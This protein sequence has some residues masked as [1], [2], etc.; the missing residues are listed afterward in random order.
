MKNMKG[1]TAVSV[2]GYIP[3]RG[4]PG[5][6]F[7]MVTQ[8][9]FGEYIDILEDKEKW[10]LI[11][12]HNDRYEGWIDKKCVEFTDEVVGCSNIVVRNG[13]RLKNVT[14]GHPVILPIGA[15]LPEP[16]NGKFLLAGNVFHSEETGGTCK[17]GELA[18]VD[19]FNKLVSIPYLWGGRC[20]F[21]FDC[22]GLTQFLCRLMGKEI[23][24][25]ASEQSAIGAPL[26]FINEAETGDLAFFDNP[27]GVIHHVGMFVEN[28]R[29]IHAS[30]T[31]RIDPIDQQGIYNE[32]L[33][34]YTYKLRV[35][36]RID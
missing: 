19:L 17:P 6:R 33:K 25:D 22:S 4:E 14:T 26:S 18:T 5:E 31:V 16:E 20:G 11:R 27:D 8:V 15:S 9:L 21:G 2:Q 28:N 10:L 32:Q 3:V 7:E 12:T 1:S 29:V 35:V 34:R 36:K 30:G 24:R 13:L 23:P